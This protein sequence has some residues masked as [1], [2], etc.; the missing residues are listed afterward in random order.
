MYCLSGTYYCRHLVTMHSGEGMQP[1]LRPPAARLP[2]RCRLGVAEII[3]LYDRLLW[4]EHSAEYW[5]AIAMCKAAGYKQ[6]ES[7]S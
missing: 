7:A 3:A 1:W 2:F 6:L 5:T 4:F